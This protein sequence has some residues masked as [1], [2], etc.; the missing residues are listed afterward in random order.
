MKKYPQTLFLSFGYLIIG[1]SGLLYIR[2]DNPE[3]ANKELWRVFPNTI[4]LCA[5]FMLIGVFFIILV[6]VTT[7]DKKTKINR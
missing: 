2:F 3:M 7:T 6:A 4:F 5:G 1:L